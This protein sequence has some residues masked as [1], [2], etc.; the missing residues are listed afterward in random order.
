MAVSFPG[1]G[2][3]ME[4][5][6]SEDHPIP[7]QTGVA[8]QETQSCLPQPVLHLGC[9]REELRVAR[10]GEVLDVLRLLPAIAAGV[11]VGLTD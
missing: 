5:S 7:G 8:G 11:G 6:S 4:I 9:I 10:A 3:D 1:G 2:V